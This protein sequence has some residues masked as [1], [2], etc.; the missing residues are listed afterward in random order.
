MP[1]TTPPSTA[2][3][4]KVEISLGNAL[5][6]CDLGLATLV[7]IRQAFEIELK[8]A[9]PGTVH[10]P[11]FE[12]KLLLGHVLS[13]DEQDILDAGTPTDIDVQG[14]FSMINQLHNERDHIVL[15]VCNSGRRSIYAA[16]LLRSLGY[17]KALS[18]AGGFQAWKKL[19]Q[20]AASP[21]LTTAPTGAP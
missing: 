10:I 1:L 5:E 12:V 13:E 2:P 8:G 4:A 14:F 19:Q 11:L 21:A 20:G 7:D 9:I 15:C 6:L 16:Q 18:V 3:E 17:P